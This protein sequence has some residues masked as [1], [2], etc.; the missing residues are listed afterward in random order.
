MRIPFSQLRF[1]RASEQVWGVNFGRCIARRAEKSFAAIKPRRR[2]ASV[3][4]P[5]PRGHR[6]HDRARTIELSPYVTGKAEYLARPPGDP[7]NDGSR[8]TPAV[9][10][11][12]R[13]GLGNNLTL[14]ATVNPDFGQVEVDPAVV[15]LSDVESFYQEKRPFFTEN[16]RRLLLRQ[17]GR[18]R[19]L[20]LQLAGADVL[21]QPAHRPRAAGR[22]AG[23][24]G[25]RRRPDGD[26]HPGRGQADGQAR[27]RLNFGT[28]HARDRARAA[29]RS[30]RT[31]SVAA[32]VEPLTYYG[33]VRGQREFH[34]GRNGS[35]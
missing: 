35:A 1:A 13:T 8:Y 23:R 21:L 10:A 15:N 18:Q 24:R 12:L 17:G 11:D 33:V 7:F 34:E 26:A 14:N 6:G 20:G 32:E 16:S 30:G 28:L 31:G 27:A 9:G 22:R 19:L 29:R 5:A 25:V 4:L 2:A 3:P